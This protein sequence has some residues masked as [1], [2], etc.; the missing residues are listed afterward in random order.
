MKLVLAAAMWNN[1]HLLVLDEP[2]NYLDRESLGALASAINDFQGAVIMISHNSG[3]PRPP[4]ACSSCVCSLLMRRYSVTNLRIQLILS[5]YRRSAAD[6][7]HDLQVM[8]LPRRGA[9]L[10]VT[11]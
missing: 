9:C 11:P 8:A 6:A 5:I 10:Q 2:T 1:P 3:M 7:R 4:P